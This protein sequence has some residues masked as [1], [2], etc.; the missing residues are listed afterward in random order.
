MLN[1]QIQFQRNKW[2]DFEEHFTLI[3]ELIDWCYHLLILYSNVYFVK[4]RFTV[5]FNLLFIIFFVDSLFLLF[6]LE[7]C[8][9][10]QHKQQMSLCFTSGEDKMMPWPII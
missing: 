5:K 1:H 3:S 2:E 4:Q 9:R 8:W 7:M 6:A 10:F